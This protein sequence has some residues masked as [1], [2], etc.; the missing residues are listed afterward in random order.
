MNAP[1]RTL[2]VGLIGSGLCAVFAICWVL[3]V[4][5]G[6]ERQVRDQFTPL[7][8]RTLEDALVNWR[9][10]AA[11]TPAPMAPAPAAS[12]HVHPPSTDTSTYAMAMQQARSAFKSKQYPQA[13]QFF[14]AAARKKPADPMPW[15]HMGD[16]YLR[17]NQ[18]RQA[19]T[20]YR[21]STV[22]SPRFLPA[23]YGLGIAYRYAGQPDEAIKVFEAVKKSNPKD[24]FANDQ[25]KAIRQQQNAASRPAG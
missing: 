4:R 2:V 3:A 23:W 13:L 15:A 9:A 5:G 21:Q 19:I 10:A 8:R 20:A 6:G 14:F 1:Q 24:K 16:C 22:L 17:T 18:P 12:E 7:Y 25:I 11:R